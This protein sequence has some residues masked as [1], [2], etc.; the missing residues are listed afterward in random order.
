MA[1]QEIDITGT[2]TASPEAVWRLLDD[3][4]TW[5]AWTS[6]ERHEEERPRGADGLGE[7]RVFRTGRYRIREEIVEREP[8]RRLTYTVLSGIPVRDYRAEI[9]VRPATGGGAEIR[10][11]T[12]FASRI[13]GLGGPLRRGLHKTTQAFVDGLAAEAARRDE[14]HA[15]GSA[16]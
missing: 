16:A 14:P 7:I 3:S 6:V 4:A 2:S 12:T 5:P 10:W 9:D 13:P 15:S 1:R 8:G 11:H